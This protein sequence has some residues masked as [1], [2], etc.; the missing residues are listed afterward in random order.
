MSNDQQGSQVLVYWEVY[1]TRQDSQI[2][3]NTHTSIFV[4]GKKCP[5]IVSWFNPL[6][7]DTFY[8]P[9]VSVV[10]GFDCTFLLSYLGPSLLGWLPVLHHPTVKRST[11]WA[12][13]FVLTVE[14]H[15]RRFSSVHVLRAE[16]KCNLRRKPMKGMGE[17]GHG[18]RSPPL[19]SSLLSTPLG[20]ILFTLNPLFSP[21]SQITPL[22]EDES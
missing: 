8:G 14:T 22:F 17:V 20:L 9:S 10:T 12:Y 5:Y 2:P 7:S 3:L 13:L 4:R 15:H 21:P 16:P 6:N 18:S 19:S 11:G 1:R